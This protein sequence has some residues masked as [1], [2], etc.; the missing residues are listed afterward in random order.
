MVLAQNSQAF[1]LAYPNALNLAGQFDGN[2]DNGG[3]LLRLEDRFGEKILE[4]RYD[5]QWHPATDGHGHALVIADDST[6]WSTWGEPIHWLAAVPSPGWFHST[7]IPP[8]PPSVQLL[9][10]T[11]LTVQLAGSSLEITA[12]AQDIDGSIGWVRFFAGTNLLTELT[13]PPYA[14]TWSGAPAGV[15]QMSAVAVDNTGLLSTSAVV[16]VTFAGNHP[17]VART[18]GFLVVQGKPIPL[19]ALDLLAN[20]SDPDGDALTLTGASPSTERGFKLTFAPG[21]VS[22]A[23]NPEFTGPDGFDYTIE[24]S[25]GA[26]GT[27]RVDLFV[28]SG[29]L[30]DHNQ[31]TI[32]RRSTGYRLR[33]SAHPGRVCEVQRAPSLQDAHWEVL[34]SATAPAHGLVEFTD[35]T[36]PPAE[37]YYR[38]VQR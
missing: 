2:L 28:Y 7:P 35:T 26:T 12:Q 1:A 37:T 11:N 27:G 34:H 25:R 38:A 33:Y 13:A 19:P 5:N 9:Q 16:S 31:L 30:P 10:P 4:F 14:M 20:D 8:H 36:P 24:D 23:P 29:P 18:D 15:Y 6:P 3:E 32:A 22:Y 17:P 21:Q